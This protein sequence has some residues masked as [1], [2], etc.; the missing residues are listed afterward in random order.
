[1]ANSK[2]NPGN[3]GGGRKNASQEKA[4]FDFLVK[5]WDGDEKIL[6]K[7]Q[8]IVSSGNF[9]AKHIV[10]LKCLNGDEKLLKTLMDKLFVNKISNEMSIH[11]E[12]I[13]EGLNMIANAIRKSE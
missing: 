1:M 4:D 9:G 2:G 11:S 6:D 8:S 5:L 12:D 3:K 7:I 13:N 10:A